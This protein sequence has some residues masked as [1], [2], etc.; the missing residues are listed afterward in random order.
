[1]ARRALQNI[2]LD[3][4]TK[5]DSLQKQI[6]SLFKDGIITKDLKIW[7]HEVRY[8]GNDAAHPSS[9]KQPVSREDAEDILNLLEQFTD[10]LYIAP[11]IAEER[12]KIRE[13]RI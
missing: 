2:C 13:Q 3:K 11:F 7:A 9:E 1:M 12:R 8:V 4:K 5:E 10:V 6:D